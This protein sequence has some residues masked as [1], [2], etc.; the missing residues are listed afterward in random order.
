MEP[1]RA[2]CDTHGPGT[3]AAGFPS[4]LLCTSAANVTGECP[5]TPGFSCPNAPNCTGQGQVVQLTG[6]CEADR[7]G[8]AL[9][10]LIN[11]Q[12]ATTAVC[13]EAGRQL[14]VSVR[15][16]LCTQAGCLYN[17]SIA[18]QLGSEW[19]GGRRGCTRAANA[20]RRRSA[21]TPAASSGCAAALRLSAR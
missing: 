13:P 4:H 1:G 14:V 19:L 3:D 9:N 5:V 7:D 6:A 17:S 20:G 2:R 18:F 12:P 11:G 21:G 15:P 16:N 10:Y 8:V